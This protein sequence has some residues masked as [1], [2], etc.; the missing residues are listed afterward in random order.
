[1]VEVID[2]VAS[3]S[4]ATTTP[5][6]NTGARPLIHRFKS[7]YPSVDLTLE[8]ANTPALLQGLLDDGLDAVFFRPGSVPPEN[9]KMQRLPDEAMKIVMPSTH[10]LAA[11]KRLPLRALANEP[12]CWCR[13]PRASHCTTKSCARAA[14]RA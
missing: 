10:P 6:I 5:A 14:R 12:S 3:P 1:M 2:H 7:R 9:V 13:G 11:K 4:A 8:E